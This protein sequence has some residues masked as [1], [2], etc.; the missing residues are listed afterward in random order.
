MTH[1]IS[2]RRRLTG[3][4]VAVATVAL[5]ATPAL[6]QQARPGEPLGL[7]YLSWAGKPATPTGGLR[8][9]IEV[10]PSQHTVTTAPGRPNRYGAALAGGNGLTPA[11]VWTGGP[12]RPPVADAPQP[13]P[14]PM[15]M[16]RS[17]ATPRRA[18][19]M[20]QIIETPASAP[21]SP[22]MADAGLT[23]SAPV[24]DPS[25]SLRRQDPYYAAPPAVQMAMQPTPQPTYMPPPVPI[26]TATD[27]TAPSSAP[28]SSAPPVA[29]DP[30]APRPDA[31]I[32]RMNQPAS[33]GA[34]QPQQPA[35]AAPQRLAEAAPTQ[36]YP[37]G[38]PGQPP[39]VGAR[40]YSVHREA[41]H[42]PDPLTLPESVFIG[43]A[44][45]DLA[46]P[47][48]APIVPRSINGRTQVVVPNQD[49]TLP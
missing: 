37:A 43:G 28:P 42:S 35:Q 14:M 16:P 5:L 29:H 20:P 30:M 44:A 15:P 3:S 46:E 31:L 1:P 49:P 7:R 25:R 12:T 19:G 26:P 40:Y 45:A 10:A 9:A 4:A 18:Q 22:Q 13:Q 21:S 36:S 6:A 48:P 47:P 34:A 38:Q 27:T 41:G 23:A 24:Y 11:S 32:F 17:S 33:T 2:T 8:G 39:R